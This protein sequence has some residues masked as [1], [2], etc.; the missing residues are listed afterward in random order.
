L[1]DFVYLHTELRRPGVTLELLHH[2]YLER[3]PDGYRYSQFCERYR[4]WVGK[5]RRSMRQIHRG[6]EKL[7][8]DYAGQRPPAVIEPETGERKETELFV[9]VLGASSF[10]FAEASWT[11]QS[12]DWIASHERAFEY[13]GGVPAAVVPDQLRSGISAPC[14][15]EAGIQRIYQELAEHYG[16]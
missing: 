16:T 12:Q 5:Q 13:L 3:H 10:T 7:F 9:A 1:P 6:G 8:V 14:R 2:E 4:H 15:Y 11:Q